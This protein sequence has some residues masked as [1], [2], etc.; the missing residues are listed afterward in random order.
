MKTTYARAFTNYLSNRFLKIWIFLKN[1]LL[2]FV[3]NIPSSGK[4]TRITKFFQV[5]KFFG[6]PNECIAE[7]EYQLNRIDLVNWKNET[8]IEA[9]EV[10]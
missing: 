2:F 4:D 8:Q 9:L 7:A 3:N 6:V 5:R 10:K 1:V